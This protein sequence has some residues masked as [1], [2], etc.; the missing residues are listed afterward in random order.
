MWLKVSGF[1]LR[2]KILLLILLGGITI[3]MGYHAK[4]VEMSYEYASLLSKK[5]KTYQDYQKFIQK[6]GEEGNLIVVGI[7]DTAFFDYENFRE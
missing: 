6:F 7:T 5:D 2:N 3:F 4:Q 1:I